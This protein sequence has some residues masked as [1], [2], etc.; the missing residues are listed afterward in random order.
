MTYSIKTCGMDLHIRMD[1]VRHL[2]LLLIILNRNIYFFFFPFFLRVAL[3]CFLLSSAFQSAFILLF[4]NLPAPALILVLTLFRDLA[5][6]L[7]SPVGFLP[8][9]APL[10][11]AF[12]STIL[13]SET[14]FIFAPSLGLFIICTQL[15]AGDIRRL[16]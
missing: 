9:V 6:G 16:V 14:L 4:L 11:R 12:I 8:V 2:S 5:T 10:Q 3:L 15:F 13:I 1:V 7:T